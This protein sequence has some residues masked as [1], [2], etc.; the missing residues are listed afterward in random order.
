MAKYEGGC[1]CGAVCYTTDAEPVMA[2]HCQC[3]KCQKLSG[4]GHGSF[5]AFPVGAVNLKGRLEYWSYTADSGN[6]ASRGH[7]PVCGSMVVGKTSGHQDL[8]A[9][10]L[11]SLDD[12]SMVTPQM[13]FF[14][15]KAMPWDHIDEKLMRFPAMPPM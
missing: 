3:R 4:A 7:C 9:I 14:N 6:T 1:A 12:P 10:Q 15:A 11:T 13:V 8:L 2:G 5:A